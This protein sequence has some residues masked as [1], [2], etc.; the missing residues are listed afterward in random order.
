MWKNLLPNI[1]CRS[2][3]DRIVV[4]GVV[5]IPLL[6]NP[7]EVDSFARGESKKSPSRA[8]L[9]GPREQLLATA[10]EAICLGNRDYN[11]LVLHGPRHVGKTHVALG[12]VREFQ[13]RW[14]AAHV[15]VISGKKLPAEYASGSPS[16]QAAVKRRTHRSADLLVVEDVDTLSGKPAQGELVRMLDAVVARGGQVVVTLAQPPGMARLQATLETRLEA[17]LVLPLCPP[18]LPVRSSLLAEAASLLGLK[19]SPEACQLLAESVRGTVPELYEAIQQLAS[20][21]G[22]HRGATHVVSVDEVRR[23]L[24]AQDRPLIPLHIL[25]AGAARYYS[26]RVADLKSASRQRGVVSARAL[27]MYL[28]RL[29]TDKSLQQIGKYFGNRDHTTVLHNCRRVAQLLET[30]DEARRAVQD[31]TRQVLAHE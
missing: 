23:V 10:V 15:V 1:F 19:L 5:R 3:S 21:R 16:R 26:L 14:P 20:Q 29:Y 17:G 22:T 13:A 18:D 31:V 28:S 30:D 27:A 9:G 7:P 6:A 8:F 25:A 4:N 11:P 12:L 2:P 24:A